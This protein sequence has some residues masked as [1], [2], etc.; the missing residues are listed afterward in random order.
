MNGGMQRIIIVGAGGQ[1]AI[2]ADALQRAREAGAAEV[3]TG[4]VDDLES[5]WGTEV[6]GL[7]VLG[8]LRTLPSLEHD[9][10]VVAVGDNAARRELTGLLLAAGERLATARHP[11]TSVAPSATIGAGSMLSAGAVILPRA[12]IGCGVIVNTRA[13]V[14]HDSVVGDFAHV[15]AGATVGAECRIGGEALIAVGATVTSRMHV[16]ARATI[17]AGAVVV[18]HVPEG[19]RALG[20]PARVTSDP[21]SETTSP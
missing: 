10:I 12:A 13:S 19:V 7:P 17:G 8:P 14:D 20:V 2:V 6:L 11:F 15:S 1:G 3:A 18:R 5:R 21:R 4:F 9:A 16:G